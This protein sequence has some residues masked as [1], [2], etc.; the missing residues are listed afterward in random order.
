MANN[1]PQSFKRLVK[2][3]IIRVSYSLLFLSL[4]LGITYAVLQSYFII[5]YL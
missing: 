1:S 3:I 4:Y 2:S 5:N